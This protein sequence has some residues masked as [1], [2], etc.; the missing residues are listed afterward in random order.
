MFPHNE[1]LVIIPESNEFCHEIICKML[2]SN[3]LFK[4]YS[5]KIKEY[6][7]IINN[8][9]K[10]INN[11]LSKS[12]ENSNQCN[13]S[14]KEKKN[15]YIICGAHSSWLFWNSTHEVKKSHLFIYWSRYKI[16]K[17]HKLIPYKYAQFRIIAGR[18]K[19]KTRTDNSSRSNSGMYNTS[20][21]RT[22]IT[23]K[24]YNR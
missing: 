3:N 10:R 15:E 14:S 16:F 2:E 23:D 13:S 20:G 1:Y 21:S 18:S 4:K 19:K 24:V 12:I 6:L 8:A 11:I 7:V 5:V 17:K 22:A 9:S